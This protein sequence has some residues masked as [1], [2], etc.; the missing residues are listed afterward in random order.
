MDLI[1]IIVVCMAVYGIAKRTPGLVGELIAEAEAGR[2]DDTTPFAEAIRDRLDGQ[3]TEPVTGRSPLGNL[4]G[5]LVRGWMT[6]RDK[7]RHDAAAEREVDAV[8][9]RWERLKDRVADKVHERVT[10][11]QRPPAVPADAEPGT[12]TAG[13]QPEDPNVPGGPGNTQPD[14]D[15]DIT[16]V[17]HNDDTY[18]TGNSRG[19]GDGTGWAGAPDPEPEQPREPIRVQATVG[20]PLTEPSPPAPPHEI[21]TQPAGTATAVLERPEGEEPMSNAVATNG[22]VIT[23]MQTGSYEMLSINR[24]L[25]AAVQQFSG[26]LTMLQNRLNRA[27]ESTVGTVQLSTGSTVMARMAQAAEAV[28]ALRAAASTCTAEVQPLLLRTKAEFDKRIS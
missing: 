21:G 7:A 18:D 1:S 11:W 23:G 15:P 9:S 10:G 14:L 5:N 25:E 8:R 24:A 16:E 6:D 22:T 13:P 26:Q 20:D 27:G 4:V 12:G 19:P 2:R 28:A 3:G 17:I